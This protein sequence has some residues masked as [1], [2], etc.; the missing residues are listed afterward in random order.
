MYIKQH[1][2]WLL[3]QSFMC[4]FPMASTNFQLLGTQTRM[5]IALPLAATCAS[6]KTPI[7]SHHLL[8][9][10][11]M[12]E[13]IC[14]FILFLFYFTSWRPENDPH[15]CLHTFRSSFLCSPCGLSTSELSISENKFHSFILCCVTVFSPMASTNPTTRVQ[16]YRSSSQGPIVSLPGFVGSYGPLGNGKATNESAQNFS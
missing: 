15:I 1:V 8:C 11:L 4:N 9:D 10:F 13:T 6:N 3:L 14:N 7:A 2:V 12:P 16:P 5:T